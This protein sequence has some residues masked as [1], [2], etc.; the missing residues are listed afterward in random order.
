M[1]KRRVESHFAPFANARQTEDN[2][3]NEK[4]RRIKSAPV[5]ITPYEWLS[6]YYHHISIDIR[7]FIE[8]E[9]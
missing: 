9:Q 2:E 6:R 3:Q 8:G 7:R 5:V 4:N 1:A